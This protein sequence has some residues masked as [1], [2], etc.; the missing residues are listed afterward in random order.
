MNVRVAL[1]RARAD[2][3][4]LAR[5][6]KDAYETDPGNIGMAHTMFN[7]YGYHHAFKEWERAQERVVVLAAELKAWEEPAPANDIAEHD[8]PELTEGVPDKPSKDWRAFLKRWPDAKDSVALHADLCTALQHGTPPHLAEALARYHP[9]SGAF[10]TMAHWARI[11]VAH[12]N[13]TEQPELWL[14]DREP[15]PTVLME[16]LASKAA[17]KKRSSGKR[18]T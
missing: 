14:P 6:R 9:S 5:A 4:R 8:K 7:A 13:R 15:V 10:Q 1:E 16:L 3:Q 2:E 17:K 18:A 12:M 11:E